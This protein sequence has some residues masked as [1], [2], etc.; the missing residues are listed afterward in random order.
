MSWFQARHPAAIESGDVPEPPVGDRPLSALPSVRARALAFAAILLAGACGGLIGWSVTTIQCAGSCS[1]AGALGALV[2]SVIA[3]GG[4]AVV[5]VLALRAMGEW[6][7]IAEAE[8]L[9]EQDATQGDQT[10]SDRRR[11]P[12]A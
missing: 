10:D 4:G 3:A 9:N 2:G 5:A 6:K 7:R 11:N 8:L 1:T 12:S